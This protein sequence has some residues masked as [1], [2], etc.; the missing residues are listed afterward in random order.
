MREGN[1]MDDFDLVDNYYEDYF[2]NFVDTQEIVAPKE[3]D[4]NFNEIVAEKLMYDPIFWNDLIE[5]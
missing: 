4:Q 3:I 1:K 5:A 2:N